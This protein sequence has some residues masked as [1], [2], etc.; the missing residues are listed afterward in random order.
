MSD[1]KPALASELQ[2]QGISR[3]TFLKFCTSIA[4]AMA[5]SPAAAAQMAETLA[6]IKPHSEP[7]RKG[8]A[9]AATMAPT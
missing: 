8:V 5:L 4:S 3:R 9:S 6:R 1:N 7:N 2:R